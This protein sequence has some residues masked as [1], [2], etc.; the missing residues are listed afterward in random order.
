MITYIGIGFFPVVY[1]DGIQPVGEK[2]VT[3]DSYCQ[4]N[5]NRGD[6]EFK[7]VIKL[8]LFGLSGHP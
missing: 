5:K 1:N 6:D 7:H 2:E 4:Q 3:A 8:Q